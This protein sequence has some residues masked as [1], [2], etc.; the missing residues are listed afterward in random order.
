MSSKYPTTAVSFDELIRSKTHKVR[1]VGP[2]LHV[3]N[4]ST[5]VTEYILKKEYSKNAR[6]KLVPHTIEGQLVYIEE[7]IRER[8]VTV[9]LV[10]A[11]SEVILEII[12]NY[13][14]EGKSLKEICA[15]PD[16]PSYT[17]LCSWKRNIPGVEEKI[18]IAREDRGEYLR[19]MALEAV[20]DTDEDTVGVDTLKHKALVWAAGVD[21]ARYSPKAKIEA[22]LTAPTQIIVNTGIRR[23]EDAVQP[24]PS[25]QIH[26]RHDTRTGAGVQADGE[27]PAILGV[28]GPDSD[29]TTGDSGTDGDVE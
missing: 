12:C 9:P 6:T 28:V 5:G 27:V 23:D 14:V 20:R 3:Y 24:R 22:T 4:I 10:S 13:I 8:T 25:E 2:T 11:Y 29:S 17:T 26:D 7:D 15:M 1:V 21:N 16:M 19:D 18:A